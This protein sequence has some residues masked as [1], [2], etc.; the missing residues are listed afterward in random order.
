MSLPPSG[1]PWRPFPD[2]SEFSGQIGPGTYYMPTLPNGRWFLYAGQYYRFQ[3]DAFYNVKGDKAWLPVW[4]VQVPFMDPLNIGYFADY[5]RPIPLAASFPSGSLSPI[6]QTAH[7]EAINGVL[8]SCFQAT[9]STIEIPLMDTDF[10]AGGSDASLGQWGDPLIDPVWPPMISL[11]WDTAQVETDNVDNLDSSSLHWTD[12]GVGSRPFP[13]AVYPSAYQNADLTIDVAWRFSKD[14][15]PHWNLIVSVSIPA[16]S[17]SFINSITWHAWAIGCCSPTPRFTSDFTSATGAGNPGHYRVRMP[18]RLENSVAQPYLS[19]P[20][21]ARLNYNRKALF[22]AYE[23]VGP[24]NDPTSGG[25]DGRIILSSD[26]TTGGTA[27][28]KTTYP[29]CVMVYGDDVGNTDR[30]S[31]QQNWRMSSWGMMFEQDG[32]AQM[33]GAVSIQ[34]GGSDEYCSFSVLSRRSSASLWQVEIYNRANRL[35]AV[36]ANRTPSITRHYSAMVFGV[37]NAPTTAAN[38]GGSPVYRCWHKAASGTTMNLSHL[39][40]RKMWCRPFS[41]KGSYG[42]V[43]WTFDGQDGGFPIFDATKAGMYQ[44]LVQDRS[45]V[46]T[47]AGCMG[48]MLKDGMGPSPYMSLNASD[49]LRWECLVYAGA[50]GSG[51]ATQD[52]SVKNAV[53]IMLGP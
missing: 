12:L 29:P 41:I 37:D 7:V 3:D 15:T 18:F 33:N 35:N 31:T 1:T 6:A 51:Q 4:F 16:G 27:L 47:I 22:A 13:D 5:G 48:S 50:P 24:A 19:A 38:P 10:V 52:S 39:R 40:E 26:G 28:L 53:A 44:V 14:P 21:T 43:P 20:V 25:F 45:G 9:N 42:V 30:G 8:I 34:N 32:I 17:S 11:R 2:L 23:Y 49:G 46:W 36:G